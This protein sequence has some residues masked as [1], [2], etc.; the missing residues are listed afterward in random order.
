MN[1]GIQH[2]GGEL[3]DPQRMLRELDQRAARAAH[4]AA[5]DALAVIHADAPGSFA[6]ESVK[7]RVSK[8]PTG[9]E[10][11]IQPVRRKRNLARLVSGGT[12]IHGPKRRPI[13]R[14]T[15]DGRTLPMRI[16]GRAIASSQG[17]RPNPFFARARD[18]ASAV[19]E[20]AITTAGVRGPR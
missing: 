11:A 19:A 9:Y 18:R 4:A 7:P 10:I 13:R 20:R 3:P 17:Q 5:A 15:P 6:R 2:L 16:R 8:T 1:A 12:G 14:K